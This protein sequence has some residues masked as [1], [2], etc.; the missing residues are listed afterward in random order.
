MDLPTYTNIWRVDKR[1]HQLYDFRLPMP[2][3]VTWI[4]VFTGITIPSVVY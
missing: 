2:M 4:S 3:P 1:L